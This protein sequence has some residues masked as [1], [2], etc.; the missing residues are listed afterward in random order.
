MERTGSDGAAPT[1][2]AGSARVRTRPW[3]LYLV[4]GVLATALY[5]VLPT[6]AASDILY[7]FVGA[8]GAAAVIAGV[9]LHRPG[10]RAAWYLIALGLA[11]WTLG[12][13]IWNGYEFLL[14]GAVPFPSAA[15]V[16]YLLGYPFL[17]LGF[18]ALVRTRTGG[19]DW[20]GLLDAA[21]VATGSA[22]VAWLVVMEPLAA[23]GS[24]RPLE[25]L[26]S[27]A[28]PAFDLLILAVIVR[29]VLSPSGRTFAYRMLVGSIVLVFVADVVYYVLSLTSSI[30]PGKPLYVLYLMSYV[31]CGVAALHP[32]M[33]TATTRSDRGRTRLE[34]R[35]V[36]LWAAACAE[37]PVLF[38]VQRWRGEAV[39]VS[40]I[41]LG[42]LALFTLVLARMGGLIRALQTSEG[43]ERRLAKDI[44]LIVESTNEGIVALDGEG[45]CTS[46]NRAALEM[47]KLDDSSQARGQHV[48]DL[49]HGGGHD[50][51]DCPLVAP[52]E[53]A[54]GARREE[55]LQG[56]DGAT[57]PAECS[58]SPILDEGGVHGTVLTFVDVS[59][60]K[61]AEDERGELEAQLRQSQKMEA[62][63]RLAGGVAHEFNNLLAVI[64]SYARFV[65][66]E[67]EPRDPRR[68]DVD[69]VIRAGERA[70]G[71]VRQLLAFSRKDAPRPEVVSLN[72]VIAGIEKLLGP[73]LGE[74][75]VVEARL[76]PED[77]RTTIDPGGMDQ[78]VTNLV[79]NARDAMPEGGRVVLETARLTPRDGPLPEPEMTPGDWVRLTVRDTGHGMPPEIAG[80]VFEPFF[81]TKPRGQGTGLGL[82]TAYG[83]IQRAG[84]RI[85][86]ASE[87][88][89]GTTFTIYLPASSPEAL[90]RGAL[91]DAD[92][93]PSAPDVL[94]GTRPP[95]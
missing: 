86:V 84:G 28:Y 93:R 27:L 3:A 58:F 5:Y 32:S 73:I 47:L 57:F 35:R 63:G 49:L 55:V 87:P 15:D 81:T 67:L 90:S 22:V 4:A 43:R 6:R 82:S 44:R 79:I 11:G 8:S 48:H 45:N 9:R 36:V 62:I 89:A 94:I 59:L 40:V 33:R 61:R 18:L 52:S 25:L 95:G 83:I 65:R 92:R 38:F 23:D 80:R 60:R 72:E 64:L 21:I 26:F 37:G 34:A 53:T 71:L 20:P 88:G 91:E 41:I 66:D 46:M 31:A 51:R 24:L 10:H 50:R 1:A 13:F 14:R 19:R 85:F 69:E 68:L 2:R 17:A 7:P 75:V 12:D 30:V 76:S 77:C 70:T 29:V 78:V 16:L 54:T 56:R 74:D 42:S 39:N